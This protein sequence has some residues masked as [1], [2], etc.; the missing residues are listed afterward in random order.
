[1]IMINGLYVVGVLMSFLIALLIK[2]EWDS[3]FG[4]KD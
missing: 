4:K 3:K 1:M 2:Y